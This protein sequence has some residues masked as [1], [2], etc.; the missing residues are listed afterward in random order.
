[1]KVRYEKSCTHRLRRLHI[2][3]DTHNRADVVP[4]WGYSTATTSR[5]FNLG[6]RA[7]N[8]YVWQGHQQAN[9]I[10]RSWEAGDANALPHQQRYS[11]EWHRSDLRLTDHDHRMVV[12]RDGPRKALC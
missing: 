3:D 7:R 8:A 10:R 12:C 2:G 11:T 5:S 1:R 9:W 4:G 6:D